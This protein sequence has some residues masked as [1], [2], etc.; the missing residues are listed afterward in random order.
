MVGE[1]RGE[2]RDESEREVRGDTEREGGS[3]GTEEV[4]PPLGNKG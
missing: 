2:G 3:G 4:E 1:E